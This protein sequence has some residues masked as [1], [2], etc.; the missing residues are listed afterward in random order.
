MI[1]I[2]LWTVIFAVLA[3]YLLQKPKV[4]GWLRVILRTKTPWRILAVILISIAGLYA[5]YRFHPR[6]TKPATDTTALFEKYSEKLIRKIA[7][8]T[9]VK[10]DSSCDMSHARPEIAYIFPT[11][12]NSYVEIVERPTKPIISRLDDTLHFTMVGYKQ[13]KNRG[14]LLNK[15]LRKKLGNRY[16]FGI[17][18]EE[19]THTLWVTYVGTPWD[20]EQLCALPII[21]IARENQLDPALLMSLIRHVSNFDFDYSGKQDAKGILALQEGDGLEQVHLGAQRLSKLL[22]MGFSTENAIATFYPEPSLDTKPDNW[23][24]SPLIKSWVDQVLE[25]VQFY[26]ENGLAIFTP[27]ASENQ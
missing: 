10:L 12:L 6:E 3:V 15:L 16:S 1:F 5:A 26:R 11:I 22:Q 24:K 21:E 9:V 4:R 20:I 7:D 25:D 17:T 23:H 19:S 27:L 18:S 14:I 2:V 13:F 8:G